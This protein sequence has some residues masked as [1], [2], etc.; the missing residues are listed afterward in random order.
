ME[1]GES[2]S[3]AARNNN[4]TNV[5]LR[6]WIE[7]YKNDVEVQSVS[8]SETRQHGEVEILKQHL[9]EVTKER[10]VL[11]AALLIIACEASYQKG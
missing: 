7:K 8:R 9:H 2:I 10:D 4:I 3:Q 1:G 5:S 11:K 6:R